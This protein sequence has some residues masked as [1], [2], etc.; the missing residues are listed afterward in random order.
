MTQSKYAVGDEYDENGVTGTVVLMD[1]GQRLIAKE[2]GSA[3]WS[4]ENVV[5]GANDNSDGTI[6]TDKIKK[7]PHWATLYPA[8][9]LCDALNTGGITGWYLPASYELYYST[10]RTTDSW[11]STEYDSDKAYI[12]STNRRNKNQ[13]CVVYAF[14]KF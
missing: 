2:V 5:T 13:E 11:S 9:A 10:L 4:T 7:I 3:V 6:N 1:E 8:F 12:S 14:R